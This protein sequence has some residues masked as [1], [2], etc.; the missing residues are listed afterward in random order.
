MGTEIGGR[1]RYVVERLLPL[2]LLLI[3]FAQL[4]SAVVALSATV[5]EG[6][7]ITSGYEYVRTGNLRLF[8]EHTP[9][10]KALLAWPLL[11]IPDLPAPE[12]APGY[13]TGD[14]IQVAQG[15]ILAYRP[16]DRVVVAARVPV[17]LLT[18][19][20]GASLYGWSRRRFGSRAALVSLSLLAF[21][22]N[23]LAHGSL[24][25]TD[26]GATAF[27]FWATLAFLDYL[28]A[29]TPRRWWTAALLLGLAQGAKLTSLLLYPV[30]ALL[31]ILT[32]IGTL[33]HVGWRRALHPLLSYAGMVGVSLLVLWALYGFELRPVTALGGTLPLPAAGHL[34]RWLRLQSN[35][36]Y[37]REAFL[38]GQN[39]MQGWWQYFPVAFLV[40]TPLPALVLGSIAL[41]YGARQI[42]YCVWRKK[43]LSLLLTSDSLLLMLFPALYA[44]ASLTSPLNIGYRHLLPVL[45]F[46]Y[47]AV[48]GSA[49]SLS[50]KAVPMPRH[51]LLPYYLLLTALLGWQALGTLRVSP[52]YLA[53]FNEL[54]G[55]PESGWRFLADS[56]TDWGQTF[57]AL[58]EYQAA[59]DLGSVKLSA[60][61]FYDPAAYGVEYEPLVPMTGAPP[62]LPRRFNPPA[63][64]YAISATTLDGVPLPYPPTF[65]WFR[66][67]EPF[68]KVGYAIFLYEV[69][70]LAGAWIAQC[71]QPVAPLPTPVVEEGLGIADLR[72]VRFN[73]DESWVLPGGGRQPGWYARA[74]APQ[75]GLR[76]PTESDGRAGLPT[77]L[78]VP[79][80]PKLTL[81]YVQPTPGE[82]PAFALWECADCAIE[83]A[84]SRGV[85]LEGRLSFLGFSAPEKAAAGEQVDVL[86]YWK[87][88]APPDRPLS[89]KLHLLDDVGQPVAVGDGLGF[90]SAHWQKGD[91][92]IQRHRL[93]VPPTLLPKEYTLRT[94]VYWL[95][96]LSNLAITVSGDLL[97]RQL[98]VHR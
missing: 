55:G 70:P 62:V 74:I 91:L 88:L 79:V 93:E 64:L 36:D 56:N 57:K 44:L 3:L 8:D 42:A 90:P 19:L 94:G 12:E 60:F 53:F 5:D 50:R 75:Q 38:L 49:G 48:A 33:R 54:A 34:E 68:H 96:D 30:L 18:V 87:V 86:T 2:L 58:A 9:L 65:D 81:S 85:D 84:E 43:R 73:C 69:E 27:I 98:E 17:T 51:P 76:W 89:I 28:R 92:F 35:L 82:L 59:H 15:T 24:A 46:L 16:L 95:N 71:T 23:V 41:V 72:E 11:L 13:A 40:K 61:T 10:V 67:R 52:H 20:L 22:P 31:L 32:R 7:H 78:P 14:L 63:G 77:W 39:S 4:L 45:P 29:P 47:L 66:H 80:V 1:L 6:F 26:L 83:P 25:T 21:A 37:G 97:E